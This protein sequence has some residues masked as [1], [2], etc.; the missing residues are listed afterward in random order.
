[1]PRKHKAPRIVE[2]T[3]QGAGDRVALEGVDMRTWH[4]R[5]FKETCHSLSTH[6]G[7]PSATQEIML[8]RVAALTVWCEIQ[9]AF[10]CNG[11]PRFE[12]TV[13]TSAANTIGRLCSQLGVQPPQRDVTPDLEAYIDAQAVAAE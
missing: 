5:R 12:L 13:Y 2:M 6:C 11:D 7:S 3:R 8:R 4:G 1:M 10:L 9:E